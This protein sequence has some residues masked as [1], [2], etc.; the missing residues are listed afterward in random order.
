MRLLIFSNIFIA[1]AAVA[2]THATYYLLGAGAASW[3]PPSWGLLAL[4][5]F[6]TLFVYNLDRLVS[7]SREDAVAVTERHTWID[8]HRSWLWAL[9][10]VGGVGSAASFWFV[11]L[12]LLWG[13]VP[14]GVVT[15]AYSLPVW[16]RD[17]QKRRLK[18][19]PG[20]KIFLIALVWSSVT[21]VLPALDAGVEVFETNAVLAF[22]ERM[23][24][25]FAIT[26][27][28]D[29]RD[30]N[31]D[32][33]AGIYTLPMTLGVHKTRWLAV[34]LMLIFVG[35]VVA[36]YGLTVSSATIPMA[37]SGLL[38]AAAL[39]PSHKVHGE[40]YYVGLLDGTMLLQGVLVVGYLVG[41][42]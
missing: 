29:V 30:M 19:V 28:F 5:F 31:R 24:F 4:V 33:Q 6:A 39:W 2:L 38:T 14:L 1:L 10:A 36:H 26:L 15:L 16:A 22:V 32:A 34:G 42:Q 17:G 18:D 37:L 11:P 3:L 35:L 8:A 9:A 25:I 20:L 13:L 27:P 21:V 12:D 23:I 40:L 41:L 7:I